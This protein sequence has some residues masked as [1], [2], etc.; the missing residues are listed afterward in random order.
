MFDAITPLVD[1]SQPEPEPEVGVD[2]MR[3]S[4][5]NPPE[6]ADLRTDI[7]LHTDDCL[8]NE[9][10]F[11]YDQLACTVLDCEETVFLDK[12]LI[13]KVTKGQ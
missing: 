4:L 3:L 5:L 9:V 11:G 10:A 13:Y 2:R 7:I 1:T 8:P 6:P 12:M